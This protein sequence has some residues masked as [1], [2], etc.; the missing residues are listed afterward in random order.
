MDKGN[1]WR[2]GLWVAIG[3][4]VILTAVNV[5]LVG[6]PGIPV[7]I[8]GDQLAML[9]LGRLHGDNYWPIG[10]YMGFAWP[11]GI[12]VSYAVASSLNVPKSWSSYPSVFRTLVLLGLLYAWIA[13]LSTAFHLL[14][15]W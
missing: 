5:P 4:A 8:V 7:F 9:F 2:G 12:P 13:I 6:I 10:L 3:L 15:P 1:K 11:P 14:A